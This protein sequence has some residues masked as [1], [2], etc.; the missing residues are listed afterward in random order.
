LGLRHSSAAVVAATTATGAIGVCV[1]L[2][3][4]REVADY[5]ACITTI[6]WTAN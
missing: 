2:R 4:P 3:R 5:N 1:Q 6:H